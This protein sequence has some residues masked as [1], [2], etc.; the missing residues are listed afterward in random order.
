MDFQT[1][2]SNL[3]SVAM[4]R[5]SPGNGASRHPQISPDGRRVV[6]SS[7]ASDLVEGDDNGR[8]DVFVRDMEAGLTALLSRSLVTGRSGNGASSRPYL[9]GNGL[10]VVFTSVASDLVPDD[11][12]G[13]PDL[14]RVHFDVP[15]SDGDGLPDSW[16]RRYFGSLSR[17]DAATDSDGD[18]VPDAVEW[19]EGTSPV[20]LH[21][22]QGPGSLSFQPLTGLSVSWSV[23]PWG[24]YQLQSTDSLDAPE[25]VNVGDP[26]KAV[27]G[28]L[29]LSDTLHPP[30]GRR[31]YRLLTLW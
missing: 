1:G 7:V 30:G 31:F 9:S 4:D 14:F 24:K 28:V 22:F 16:E 19:L 11:F 23:N 10:T 5:V 12:N 6:F 20:D 8:T 13:E 15:D 18:G 17:A 21:S 29:E 27:S 2:E 3:V 25:W 26:V